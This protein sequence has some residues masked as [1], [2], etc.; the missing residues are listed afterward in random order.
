MARHSEATLAAI[1]NAV[2]IVALVSEYLP[3][4]RSGSRFKGLCPFHDDHN[5]SMEVNPESQRYKCWSCGA[6]G[7]VFD[8]VKDYER[9]EFPE[10]LRILAE[11]AGVT[12]ETTSRSSP[13]GPAKGDILA[14]NAWAEN[15][16]VGLY[17]RH[18]E[19][20]RYVEERG[21]A[22]ASA[23]A[24][25][26]GYAP[27][28]RGWLL[29]R[30]RAKGYSTELLEAAGLV[31]RVDGG[32]LENVRERFRGRLIFPIHDERG[33]VLGF[34]GRIL[35]ETE[36]KWA[37]HG[38][39]IA[40]YLNSPETAVFHK[41]RVLFGVDQARAASRVAGWVAVVEGYTD[42]IAAHQAGIGNVVGTLGTALS[43]EHV[44]LLRRV[45]DR[46]V[47]VFDGD[48]AG[49]A[50]ADRALEIFLAQEVDVRVLTLP[51]RL[52]PADYLRER[53][54]E[55]L[56]RLIDGA[57]EPFAFALARAEARF[58]LGT[59]EGSRRAADWMLELLAR[60]PRQHGAGLDVKTARALDRLST[61][62][63]IDLGTLDRRFRELRRGADR[64]QQ[65][66]SAF[67]TAP[68]AS[69][70]QP[71]PA[72]ILKKR[73]ALDPVE[74]E[75]IELVLNEPVAVQG[76]IA[77]ITPSALRD[78]SLRS[79]L[80]AAFEVHAEGGF[81]GFQDVVA[82]LD[83]A[84]RALAAAL[85]L[86]VDQAPLPE[87]PSA[88]GLDSVHP[89]NWSLRLAGVLVKFAERERQDRLR[90]L[91]QMIDGAGDEPDAGP[92]RLQAL[93]LEYYRLIYERPDARVNTASR[94]VAP[95]SEGGL[96]G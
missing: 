79:I 43:E 38:K 39:T 37:A 5:P 45:A 59:I 48:D 46:V 80:R 64:R 31:A 18:D 66:A 83:P 65:T 67:A 1:K 49:Q 75:L 28:A 40:K 3:L 57:V 81:A 82:R 54:V 56:R 33:K 44:S 50:A 78:E 14:V 26:L 51:D 73:A 92:D 22:A 94:P 69:T 4:Q 72:E 20:R 10:A 12:L 90:T 29:D 42:V 88:G 24:F 68:A 95:L 19:V 52:D 23:T 25:R 96:D 27:E 13:K 74:R 15:V 91:R 58:D 11:R 7:D 89:A 62:L 32:G 9:V 76:L 30:A 34:G 71:T 53:G 16:F 2:P 8:F 63:R 17:T 35:P 6:G 77:R 84:T 41:R 85:L 55:S 87:K 60:V 21:I 86:P 47:L 70:D 36:R 93:R 61:R